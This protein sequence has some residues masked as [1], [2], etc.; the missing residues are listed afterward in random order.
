[1]DV[2]KL[3]PIIKKMLRVVNL[4]FNFM[5]LMCCYLTFK[6]IRANDIKHLIFAISMFVVGICGL[7][8]IKCLEK[9]LFGDE[10]D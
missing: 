4:M 10:D 8:F 9:F 3:I 5:L 7:F 6:T 2:N 1:M